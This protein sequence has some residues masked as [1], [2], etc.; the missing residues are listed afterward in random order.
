MPWGGGS[1][2]LQSFWKWQVFQSVA[3]FELLTGPFTTK[4]RKRP[5]GH[6][7][8]QAGRIGACLD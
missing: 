4:D 2:G 5:S 3:E 8:V 1:G 7:G 6:L